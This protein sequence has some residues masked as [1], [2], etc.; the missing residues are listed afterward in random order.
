ML[1]ALQQQQQQAAAQDDDDA[2][3][4]D[5]DDDDEP[6]GATTPDADPPTDG[7]HTSLLAFHLLSLMTASCLKVCR[8]ATVHAT[9]GLSWRFSLAWSTQC[10]A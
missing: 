2:F 1:A 6:T 5:D 7:S 9:A 8:P 10:M 4:D 3:I